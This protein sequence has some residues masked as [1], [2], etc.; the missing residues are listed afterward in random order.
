MKKTLLLI[1]F[2]IGTFA[3]Q[4][5]RPLQRLITVKQADGKSIT[6]TKQGNHCFCFYTLADGTVISKDAQGRFCYAQF[7]AEGLEAS[8][9]LAHE[10]SERSQEEILW[11]KNADCTVA[12]AYSHLTALFAPQQNIASRSI[13]GG[14]GLG[15]YGESAGGTLSSIGTPT[16]PVILVEFPDRKFMETTTDEK[17]SRFFNEKGYKDESLCHGSVSDYFTDQSNGLF[18]PKFDIVARVTTDNNYAYY[19]AN[20]SNNS[21]DPNSY[22]IVSEVVEK[23]IA[24]G[25]D[26]SQYATGN[27][28]PLVSLMYA[29]PGEHSAYEDGCEDYLW[30]HYNK[31]RP[32]TTS[33]GINV[34]SYFMGNEMLQSYKKDESGN[35]VVKGQQFD[36]MGV[37][38]HEIGHA[39]NLPDF[40]Y[41]GKS[42]SDAA[43]ILTPCVWSIMDYGQYLYDGYAPIGY[44]A[45]ERSVMGWLNVEELTEATFARLYPFGSEDLGATAYC[46]KN[47]S[48][49][50][51]YYLLE[52][53]Q[54]D[55]WF[56]SFMGTGMLVWHVAFNANRW[57]AN[58]VNNTV[59]KALFNIVP[60]DNVI[61]DTPLK[62]AEWQRVAA[63]LYPGTTGNTSLTDDTTPATTVY[64]GSGLSQPIYNI[65]E[66][67]GVISFSFIDPSLTGIVATEITDGEQPRKVY[68]IDGRQRGTSGNGLAPGVYI[69]KQGKESKKVFIK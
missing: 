67:D 66:N 50:N 65:A 21:V 56:P 45:Y 46:I 14:D 54:A 58:T 27:N 42:E 60:A 30:A 61:Y 8:D 69:V 16:I 37:F 49:K 15:T 29:G 55:T 1:A 36:G 52:N 32:F 43:Q 40:Y 24:Q 39:L 44:N 9:L 26:F 7:T 35:I 22:K 33:T 34:K 53:R 13:G 12:K 47:P 2:A 48:D 68:T 5:T 51:E 62:S 59:G 25:V 28:L 4:A 31:Y 3:A 17:V 10:A 63:N 41:T 6:V 20:G 19:G 11:L 18:S 64:T 38:I 57:S 23:A